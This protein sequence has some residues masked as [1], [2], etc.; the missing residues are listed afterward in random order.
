MRIGFCY[1]SQ[2]SELVVR[3]LWVL[4]HRHIGSQEATGQ[5]EQRQSWRIADPSCNYPN[6]G[7]AEDLQ[8]HQM[9]GREKEHPTDSK[10][11]SPTRLRFRKKRKP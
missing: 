1:L 11:D 6:L 10:Q 4:C 2:R 9:I 7:R 5:G 3:K 8:N